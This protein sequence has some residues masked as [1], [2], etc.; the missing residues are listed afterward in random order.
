MVKWGGKRYEQIKQTRA[1]SRY[2]PFWSGLLVRL[3]ATPVALDGQGAWSGA[4]IASVHKA[5]YGRGAGHCHGFRGTRDM[6]LPLDLV[7]ETGPARVVGGISRHSDSVSVPRHP[8]RHC[9]NLPAA[10]GCHSESPGQVKSGANESH[11]AS[12]AIASLFHAK[13]HWRGAADSE[14]SPARGSPWIF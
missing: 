12:P 2:R 10:G 11:T 6:L 8:P 5:M 13:S 9:R 3:G 7:Q 1:R 14:H 4:S